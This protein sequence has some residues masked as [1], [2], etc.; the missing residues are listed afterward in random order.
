[1]IQIQRIFTYTIKQA[2]KCGFNDILNIHGICDLANSSDIKFCFPYKWNNC[3]LTLLS[4]FTHTHKKKSLLILQCVQVYDYTNITYTHI[5]S[6]N[7]VVSC[8]KLNDDSP[9]TKN[10]AVTSIKLNDE[11]S[12][13]EIWKIKLQSVLNLVKRRLPH[14]IK[15]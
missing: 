4:N 10:E 8:V 1:M 11:M 5:I 9:T 7:I 13:H 6:N 15:L 2:R 14:I 12:R 3:L